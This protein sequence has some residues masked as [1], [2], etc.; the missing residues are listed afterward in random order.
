MEAFLPA[1]EYFTM[2]F[3]KAI[4]AHPID[5]LSL[6]AFSLTRLARRFLAPSPHDPLLQVKELHFLLKAEQKPKI[7]DESPS[8]E[9]KA[10]ELAVKCGKIFLSFASCNSG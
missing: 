4:R 9:T 8:W 10:K 7:H 5:S 6:A 2:R 1:F 3:T